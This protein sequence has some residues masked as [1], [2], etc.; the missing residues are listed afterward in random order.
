M[1]VPKL[2]GQAMKRNLPTFGVCLGHQGIAQYFGAELGVL[3]VP[4]HGKDSLVAHSEKGVFKNVPSP[5][6]A[7]RYHSLFVKPETV[8]DCLEITAK[9]DR[10][11]S[12]QYTS[13]VEMFGNPVYERIDAAA[14]PAQKAVLKKLSPN[15][16]TASVLAGEK[17]LA[18]LTEAP[19]NGAPIGGLKVVTENGWFAARPSGTEDIYKVYAE[20]FKGKE[21]LTQIQE[22][23]QAVISA[24]FS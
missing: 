22:E 20:S 2:V 19:G 15:Q 11:P 23:A 5:F 24:A 10:D 12:E 6:M 17:I 16:I 21:H 13:L 7:G 3:D 1:G 4:V 18:T 14:T 9:T 8:P